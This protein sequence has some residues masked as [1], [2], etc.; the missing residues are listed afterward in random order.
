MFSMAHE[1]RYSWEKLAIYHPYELVP[2]TL[3]HTKPITRIFLPLTQRW[4]LMKKYKILYLLC[5]MRP[6][7]T[8]HYHCKIRSKEPPNLLP[9]ITSNRLANTGNF[10]DVRP[11]W[12]QATC[13]YWIEP[14]SRYKPV[15]KRFA[16]YE[17][18]PIWQCVTIRVPFAPCSFLQQRWWGLVAVQGKLFVGF[19]YK[20]SHQVYF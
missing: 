9:W 10:G 2:N 15:K 18:N 1:Y 3:L 17:N 12:H 4:Y 5:S 8:E 16:L 7:G 19:Q 11:I 6:H 14:Q 13:N 20:T